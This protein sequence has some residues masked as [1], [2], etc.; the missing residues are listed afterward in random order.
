MHRDMGWGAYAQADFLS[1]NID[2]CN[3]DIVANYYRLIS[4]SGQHQHPWLLPWTHQGAVSAV[5]R[6][7]LRKFH[8]RICPGIGPP[9]R[10]PL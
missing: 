9:V 10:Y 6:R 2:D 8:S 4:L 3:L 1:P 7:D 5:C